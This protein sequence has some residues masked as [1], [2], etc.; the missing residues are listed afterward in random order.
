MLLERVFLCDRCGELMR[1]E[2]STLVA[3]LLSFLKLV[4]W[5]SLPRLLSLPRKLSLLLWLSL[6]AR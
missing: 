6:D 2:S 3:S 1:A 4:R 5:L